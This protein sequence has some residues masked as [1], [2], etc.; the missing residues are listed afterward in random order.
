MA[1]Q[2]SNSFYGGSGGGVPASGGQQRLALDNLIRRELKVGDPNDPKQIA[3]A[4]LNRFKDDPRANAITQEAKGLPFLL[5]SP[6]AQM[7]PQAPTS[8]D[9]ELQQAKDDVERDLQELLTNSLL[10][11]MTPEIQGWAQA[12]RTLI[13]EGIL[14]ARFALD[15]RQRDKAFGIR[16]QLGDFSRIARYV[17][18]LTPTMNM[19]YRKF[20]QSLDEVASILLVL[21]GEALA[22]VGFNG[23]RFLLQVPYT[24]LQSRRD[25]VIS[26]LRNLMGSTQVAWSQSEWPRGLDGYRRLHSELESQGHGDLRALL[27]EGELSRVMDELITRADHGRAEG[28]R[29][30][31]VTAQIQLERFRRLVSVGQDLVVDTNG[32]T[33]PWSPPLSAF[34]GALLLFADAFD[35]TGGFRLMR[36]ARPPILFYGLYGIRS[37]DEA[38]TRLLQLI[39]QRNLLA[40]KLD[41]FLDCGCEDNMVAC[42]IILDKILY[43][44][45]RAIDYYA[46]GT[47]NFGIPEQ[48]A[49]AFGLLI[50]TFAFDSVNPPDIPNCREAINDQGI[51]DILKELDRQLRGIEILETLFFAEFGDIDQPLEGLTSPTT[52]QKSFRNLLKKEL[53]L[54][55]QNEKRWSDMARTMA[56]DCAGT[57]KVFSKIQDLLN[58]TIGRIT[59]T[60]ECP[61]LKIEIPADIDATFSQFLKTIP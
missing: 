38:E 7:M 17:G 28:L 53:C 43:D 42:L 45:D 18:A 3:E 24:E 21:M 22:N 49:S 34:L 15:P 12:V 51:G 25:T 36:I 37:I 54:Q 27:V 41:C 26:T 6:S 2:N 5:S 52:K 1:F 33:V 19:V 31:G 50:D 16:R 44:I 46:L 4:L 48:R 57:D 47:D 14:A 20:A 8:S 9:A 55:S 29:A 59:S 11:D 32:N 23:G 30:L 13:Q 61:K 58:D 56:P 10:K 40:D 60:A 39:T 35:S